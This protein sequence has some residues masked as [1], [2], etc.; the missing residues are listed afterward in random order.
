MKEYCESGTL[1][2]AREGD[3]EAV[4]ALY[5]VNQALIRKVA[6]KLA[7][8]DNA[9][10]LE[11]LMQ[12]GFFAIVDAVTTYDE[13]RGSWQQALTWE[14]K[15]RFQQ[16]IP[17]RRRRTKT[18][19]LDTPVGED[20][21]DTLCSWLADPTAITEGAALR[22]DFKQSVHRLIRE[23]TDEAARNIILAHDM[24]GEQLQ[25]IAERLG[26]SYQA[27][28]TKRRMALLRLQGCR[29]LKDL[30][31]DAYDIEALTYGRSAEECAVLILSKRRRREEDF[32]G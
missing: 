1:K 20:D 29:E 18:V 14:L 28:C 10:G 30:Y 2:K 6:Q 26:L 9:V 32:N 23:Q 4:Y 21:E 31:Q 27:M 3:L 5:S 11:D 22:E 15:R 8:I 16:A 17:S 7:H 12:E 19:S 24:A 13:D 25:D